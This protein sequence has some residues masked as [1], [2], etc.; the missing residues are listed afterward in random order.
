L[1]V[2]SFR[3]AN[4]YPRLKALGLRCLWGAM[5]PRNT[6]LPGRS[7]LRR[8]VFWAWLVG[9][10]Y[11]RLATYRQVRRERIVLR[12]FWDAVDRQYTARM[13]GLHGLQLIIIKCIWMQLGMAGMALV[14]LA[15][16]RLA[17]YRPVWRERI[18]LRWFWDAVDRQYTAR[19][20]GTH[21]LQLI[22][23][24]CSWAWPAWL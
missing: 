5:G 21:G 1:Q 15:C 3:L 11:S 9:R 19:M 20:V 22:A 14:G 2:T 18:V 7:T 16:C 17:T 12:W 23:F 13:V 10:P 4:L 8:H 24:G 6:G